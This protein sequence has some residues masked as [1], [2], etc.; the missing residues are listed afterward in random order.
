MFR[1]IEIPSSF[2]KSWFPSGNFSFRMRTTSGLLLCLKFSV[3]SRPWLIPAPNPPDP[4]PKD[5]VQQKNKSGQDKDQGDRALEENRKTP[6]GNHQGL[7]KGYLELRPEDQGQQQ[8]CGLISPFSHQEADGSEKDHHPNIKHRIIYGI[9]A[10]QTKEHDEREQ[11]FFG[12]PQD[13][14]KKR[15]KG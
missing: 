11:Y 5:R 3:F 12:Y 10:R 14:G 13:V 4:D 9:H 2:I 7:S 15:D 6:M 8:R 1:F